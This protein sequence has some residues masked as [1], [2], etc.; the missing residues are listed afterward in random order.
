MTELARAVPGAARVI[1]AQRE[2]NFGEV[3]PHMEMGD[4][5]FWAGEKYRESTGD[6]D[7]AAIAR[8][9]L[10]EFFRRMEAAFEIGDQDLN[11]LVVVGFLEGLGLTKDAE[12]GIRAMLPPRMRRAY[13]GYD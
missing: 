10:T 8:M 12:P 7:D 9:E 13:E 2:E 11:E 5:I 4:L 1:A 6:G 3:L